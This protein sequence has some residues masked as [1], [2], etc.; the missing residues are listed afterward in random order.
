MTHNR[1]DHA[2]S[3]S[4][5]PPQK[6]LS[7]KVILG[8]MLGMSVL[9]SLLI[10]V[11]LYS[12]NVLEHDLM[13]KHALA[14]LSEITQQLRKNPDYT[15]PQT[16]ILQIYE[17]RG[18]RLDLPAYLQ[19]LPVGFSQEIEFDE[20][21]YFVLVGQ[22]DD[23]TLFIVNDIS[24]FEQLERSFALIIVISWMVLLALIFALSYLISRFMLKPI[25]DFADEIDLLE[26]EVRGRQFVGRYRGLEVEKMTRAIDRYLNKLDEYVEKQHSFAAMASHELRTPLTI[27]QTSAELISGQTE[28]EQIMAQC[29]KIMRSTTSMNDMILA[30]L[31]ITRDLSLE[32]QEKQR[33]VLADSVDEVLNNLSQQININRIEIDN[34]VRPEVSF[35]CNSALLSVVI[36]NLLTNAIKHCPGGRVQ[37]NYMNHALIILDNGEGLGT[38]NIEK[39]FHKGVRGRN[40]GGYGLGLYITKLICDHQGWHLDLQNSNPG[41]QAKVEFLKL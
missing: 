19:H 1:P 40:N 22:V 15:L 5:Q 32:Q 2:P 35:E 21:I 14:E 34:W 8:I 27:I 13:E 3:A 11:F 16:A 18:N 23:R 39:L 20:R 6:N 26:P 30:L 31:S 38:D 41:T 33:V 37:I 25:S 7:Y 10:V 28:N 12:I 29:H 36:N 4:G 17:S 24:E 9:V